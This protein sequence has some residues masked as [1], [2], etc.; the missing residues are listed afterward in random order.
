MREEI[1][2]CPDWLCMITSTYLIDMI[3]SRINVPH[4]SISNS[5][6]CPNAHTH[7]FCQG[8]ELHLPTSRSHHLCCL[9]H[10]GATQLQAHGGTSLLL[11][12]S[13]GYTVCPNQIKGCIFHAGYVDYGCP[14]RLWCAWIFLVP[15]VIRIVKAFGH[16][17]KIEWHV[18]T[19]L[20]VVVDL[21]WSEIGRLLLAMSTCV[22]EMHGCDWSVKFWFLIGY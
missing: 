9:P 13:V 8:T 21:Y 6:V 4:L 20:F 16:V 11:F 5:L 22:S 3:H 19:C 15:I 7:P 12:W 2:E 10:L 17:N 14:S 18:S 1:E